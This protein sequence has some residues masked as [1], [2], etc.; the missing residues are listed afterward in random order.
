MLAL[1]IERRIAEQKI[2]ARTARLVDLYYA[3]KRLADGMV[4][5]RAG[6][7]E[8]DPAAVLCLR[9]CIVEAAMELKK[10]HKHEN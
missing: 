7:Y 8:A 9:T 3:A 4:R 1:D 2:A 6:V 5:V 10:S